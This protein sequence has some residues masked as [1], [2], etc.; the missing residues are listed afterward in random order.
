MMS[1]PRYGLVMLYTTFFWN[2]SQ[3]YGSNQQST[4]LSA[5]VFLQ[6]TLQVN[7]SLSLYDNC[8]VLLT[9]LGIQNLLPLPFH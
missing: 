1:V 7:Y 8:K 3:S 4:V 6:E 9:E 5:F 2:F